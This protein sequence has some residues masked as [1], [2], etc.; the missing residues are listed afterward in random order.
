MQAWADALAVLLADRALVRRYSVSI[1][2]E[3]QEE[4]AH[5]LY[6]PQVQIQE[7]GAVSEVLFSPRFFASRGYQEIA[8]LGQKI[9]GLIEPGAT[10][11]RKDKV[12]GN[13]Q[14]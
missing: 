11:N 9:Q 4:G 13:W 14:L 2:Q 1:K 3:E 8:A 7:Y 10:I 12:P 6:L 5:P